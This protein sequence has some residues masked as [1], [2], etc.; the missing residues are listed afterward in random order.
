MAFSTE[1]SVLSH[2][3][4][5]NCNATPSAVVRYFQETV[6][7]NMRCASPSYQ[8][9]F[10]RGLSFIVSR[11]AF[12]IYRP[13]KE[14]EVL[15]VSTWAVETRSAAFPRCYTIDVGGERV[16]ECVMTW[17]LLDMKEDKLLRGSDFD[18]SCYGHGELLE[19]PFPSRLRIPKEMEFKSVGE[20]SV[21]FRDIDR[22]FHMN[23]TK[24]FDLLWGYIPSF[25]DFYLSECL[26]NFC[27][28]A[29]LHEK[30]EVFIS[31]AEIN[32][33][34]ELCYYFKTTADGKPNIEAKFTLRKYNS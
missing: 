15:S 17:A 32:E 24:Y 33:A 22:N 8:E 21:E 16:A 30:I 3:I 7:R 14:Y 25:E 29:K 10:N 11:T 13:I 4:D 31:N 19:L 27:G 12:K 6:D 5:T 26:M 2:D 20:I 28:E 23:N 18:T 1:L 34:D 9:L